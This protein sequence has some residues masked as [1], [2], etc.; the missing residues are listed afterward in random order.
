[1]FRFNFLNRQQ[2]QLE[3]QQRVNKQKKLMASK[4]AHKKQ[5]QRA[6]RIKQ[7]MDIQ[8][9]NKT[10]ANQAQSSVFDDQSS[11]FDDQSSVFIKEIL[12]ERQEPPL[13]LEEPIVEEPPVEEPLLLLVEEPPLLL[14]EPHVLVKQTLPEEKEILPVS[15]HTYLL[16]YIRAIAPK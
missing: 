2:S 12:L 15:I 11:V 16:Y 14:E 4:A 7:H 10:R 3:A 13:L 5:I 8:S 1:M 9:Y 6:K